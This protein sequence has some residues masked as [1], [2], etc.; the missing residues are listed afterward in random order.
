MLTKVT[1]PTGKGKLV[2]ILAGEV[3]VCARC[4]GGN[5]AGHT[6]VATVDGKKTKFDFHLLPSGQSSPSADLL[7]LGIGDADWRDAHERMQVSSTRT[8]RPSSETVSSFT[9]RPSS[10]SSTI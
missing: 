4:A 10:R 7:W 3:D 1:H 8:A 6:I 2:D 5:N 9:F